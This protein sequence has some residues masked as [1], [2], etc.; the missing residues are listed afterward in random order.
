MAVLQRGALTSYL[1]EPTGRYRVVLVFGPDRGLVSERATD[2]LTALQQTAGSGPDDPFGVT[3]I[4]GED[5]NSN[6]DRLAN[7]AYTISLFGGARF[8]HVRAHGA[9]N[10]QEQV[11]PL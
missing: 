7:E 2:I 5:L 10:L 1:K 8:I 3:R 4:S 6:P 9:R 11:A